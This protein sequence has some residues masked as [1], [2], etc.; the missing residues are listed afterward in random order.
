M[1]HTDIWKLSYG[2]GEPLFV[3]HTLWR[4]YTSDHSSLQII[5]NTIW[6]SIATSRQMIV[7]KV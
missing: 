4:S 3:P 6:H 7:S 5:Y 2:F 1:T